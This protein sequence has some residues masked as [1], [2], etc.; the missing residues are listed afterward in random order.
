M[1]HPPWPCCLSR[2]AWP[3][4][5]SEHR[6]I[7][8]SAPHQCWASLPFWCCP[9]RQRQTVQPE[10]PGTSLGGANKPLQHA[11]TAISRLAIW[12]AY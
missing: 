1:A 7:S 8:S 12:F 5:W 9:A 2:C 11:D 4:R 6:E 3:T 10:S